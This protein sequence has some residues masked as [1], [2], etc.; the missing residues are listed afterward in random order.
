M[1]RKSFFAAAATTAVALLLLGTSGG[2]QRETAAGA[3]LEAALYT[4][5]RGDFEIIISESGSLE[6]AESLLINNE[7]PRRIRIIE[8]V[9]EGTVITTADV[10]A[11]K[12]LVRLD[13]TALIEELASLEND[14]AAA[15]ANLTEAEEAL[16]I[17]ESESDSSI[18]SAQLALEF[19]RSDL[20][21][22]IGQTLATQEDLP[23][24]EAISELL[25]HSE[26]GGQTR[27]D[28]NQHHNDIELAREDV[29]QARNKLRWTEELFDSGYVT[30][31]E[32]DADALALRRQEL[33]LR[34]AQDRLQLFRQYDFV[35]NLR[36]TWS[37]VIEAEQRLLREQAKA[38]S[39]L[40]QSEARLRSR[41]SALQQVQSRLAKLKEDINNCTIV[42]TRPGIVL[43]QQPGRWNNQGPLTVGTEV[44]PRQVL[45]AIPNINEMV[46][47]VRVHEA[48]I[49]MIEIGQAAAIRVDAL[50]GNTYSGRVMRK[51]QVPSS[52]NRW[53]NPD[54]K[55]FDVR[56]SI[57]GNHLQLRPD[58]T[59]TVQIQAGEVRDKLFVPIQAVTAA[60]DNQYRLWRPDGGTLP[61]TLGR[62]NEIYVVVEGVEAG[63]QISLIPPKGI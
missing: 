19:A 23:E 44:A 6:A 1:F 18:R 12:V 32:R 53:L 9:E 39:R 3:N 57:D 59:A 26:L 22:L 30:A 33:R 47:V 2:C 14:L 42:A 55:L 54:L 16:A 25:N 60:S 51:A 38:R 8:M 45:L 10:A 49:D 21:K 48:Q 61:V 62:Q 34:T 52:Q 24:K 35:R 27:L 56:V 20:E 50:A 37:D 63:Q 41:Q 31:N 28:I 29:N 4:I 7:V 58:M 11:G 46:V 17:Q 40:A 43:H 5:N 36:K 15:H 13:A